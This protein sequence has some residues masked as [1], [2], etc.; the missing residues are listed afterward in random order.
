MATTRSA[1]TDADIHTLIKG[2]NIEER[3][4]AAHKLCRNI[5]RPDLSDEDRIQAHEILRVMAN[6]AAELVRRALAVTLKQS[7]VVP[8]DVANKLARDVESIALPL[9]NFSP[10]FN[11]EDLAE[12]V[13]LGGPV[14]QVAIAKRPELSETVTG[15]L[16]EHGGEKAVQTACANDNAHFSDRM[17]QRAIDRFENSE[18]VLDAMAYRRTLPMAVSE[19]LIEMVSD[20]VRDHL[21]NTQALSPQVALEIAMGSKERATL[22]LVDQAGKAGDVKGFAAHLHERGS[23]T[24][25]LLLRGLAHGHMAFF[26]HGVAELAGVPHHRTWLM[27]HD[28]GPLGFRAI[29]DRA[30][31]PARLFTAFRAGVDTYHSM[32]FDGGARDQERFQQRMLQR[33]LTQ[34]R[35]PAKDDVDYLMEKMDQIGQ[36]AKQPARKIS[37]VS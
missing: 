17:L 31:L 1:L 20:Q 34:P 23:L 35:G 14:R 2:A 11:D 7:A 16:V 33:F 4:L 29:Y 19:R 32:E 10:A 28:A 22:D 8:R 21:I 15:A 36:A 37:Q 12:I 13:R 18:A 25:S 5:D 27:I 24:A 30:G 3:A 9:L 26:E 6:D